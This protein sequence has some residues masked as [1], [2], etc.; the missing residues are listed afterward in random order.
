[1]TF[2]RLLLKPSRLRCVQLLLVA[3]LIGAIPTNGRAVDPTIKIKSATDTGQSAI[4]A[5]FAITNN[6]N[7]ELL[8][9]TLYAFRST[10]SGI[11]YK[12]TAAVGDVTVS[13]AGG[14]TNYDC[15]AVLKFKD[16][17][18]NVLTCSPV[19]KNHLVMSGTADN[20]DYGKLTGEG[21]PSGNDVECTNVYQEDLNKKWKPKTGKDVFVHLLPVGGG[22]YAPAKSDNVGGFAWFKKLTKVKNGDYNLVGT[23]EITDGTTDKEIAA[24]FTT[25]KVAGEVCPCPP[26]CPPDELQEFASVDSVLRPLSEFARVRQM[27]FREEVFAER[28]RTCHAAPVSR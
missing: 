21:S 14:N 26:G 5:T 6:S 13:V 8:D 22:R 9:I 12:T 15:L 25:V 18:V 24:K 27:P 17:G 7:L 16:G 1:M 3:T 28:S 2:L 10:K 20:A 4:L 19:H 23:L 11:Y